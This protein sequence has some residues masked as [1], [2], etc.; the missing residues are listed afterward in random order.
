M[1]ERVTSTLSIEEAFDRDAYALA[2]EAV[3]I[4]ERA[5][6]HATQEALA[7]E[8]I[9]GV[10][11]DTWRR[12]IEAGEAYL[13]EHKPG[14]YP[15]GGDTCPYCLQGLGDA[16]LAVVQKYRAF[17]QSDLQDA[18]ELARTE[19]RNLIAGVRDEDLEQLAQDLEKRIDAVGEGDSP[20]ESLLTARSF[21]TEFLALQ[22]TV[23]EGEKVEAGDLEPTVQAARPL[24]YARLTAL[25][26][27]AE[28]LR[29]QVDERKTLLSS[30]AAKLRDL[31]DHIT[32]SELLPGIREHVANAKW[33][34]RAK[35]IVDRFRALGRS[36]TDASKLASE[37]LLNHDFESTF[38]DECR[39]LRA[40]AVTLDFPGRKGQPARRKTLTA[41]HRLSAILSEGEQ[42]VIALADFIAEATLRR[43][44][45]PLVLDDPVTSLDYK[46]LQHVVDRLVE[47]SESRQVVVFTHNI[48]FTME[49]L[50]RF[51]KQKKACNYYDISGSGEERGFVS[52]GESPKFDTWADKKKRINLLIERTKKEEEKVMRDA[53]VEQGYENLRGACEIVVEQDLLQSVV[54]SYKPNVMVSNLLRLK[55]DALAAASATVND[56]FDRC[57][58][59][60]SS[61]KQ[62]LETLNVR[63]TLEQLVEDWSALQAIHS[64]FSK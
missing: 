19:F 58:R 36:L 4:A 21:V 1:F 3:H 12:F 48:W 9:P 22:Q 44:A 61:H 56:V 49:L 53:F 57:C 26:K 37:Q 32:L 51:E 2:L 38:T 55:F 16:A 47:L 5:H 62:P 27:L 54:Q 15:K 14:G 59:Y 35:K 23:N 6:T 42:K 34:S 20:H 28:S 40:P 10:L 39:A 52:A 46:R 45:T 43:S 7:G 33:A 29:T 41:Q 63:P 24:A 8:T 17:C 64:D 13:A 18:L 25:E 31:Q 60:I 50:A 30:E 11:E